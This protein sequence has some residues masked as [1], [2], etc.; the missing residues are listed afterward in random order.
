MPWESRFRVCDPVCGLVDV[1]PNKREA[2]ARAKKHAMECDSVTVYD[3]M[4][5]R[6]AANNWDVRGDMISFRPWEPSP[7]RR[8]Y[9]AS[10]K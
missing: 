9:E 5:K 10:S 2:M 8:G 4:A 6:G 3:L 1:Y 7:S